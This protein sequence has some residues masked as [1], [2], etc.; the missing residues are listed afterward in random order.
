MDGAINVTEGRL[1]ICIN[2]MW[3][4]VC[5]DG[6]TE[7]AG[8]DINAARVVCRQLGFTGDGEFLNY[9]ATN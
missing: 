5:N 2:G 7:N 1:E 3:G 9:M 4:A 8:F 6:I